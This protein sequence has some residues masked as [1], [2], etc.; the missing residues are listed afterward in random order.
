MLKL[1]FFG[2]SLPWSGGIFSIYGF[3]NHLLRLNALELITK[4]IYWSVGVG[5]TGVS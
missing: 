3:P 4:I 5:E 2:L 1:T